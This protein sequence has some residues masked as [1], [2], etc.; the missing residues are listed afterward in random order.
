MSESPSI[1]LII[2]LQDMGATFV[3]TIRQACN[4]PLLN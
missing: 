3:R 2:A 4:K 1:P